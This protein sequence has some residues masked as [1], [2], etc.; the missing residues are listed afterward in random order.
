MVAA[1]AN[2]QRSSSTGSYHGTGSTVA[3]KTLRVLERSNGGA[4]AGADEPRSYE[5]PVFEIRQVINFT[6]FK[7]F[8]ATSFGSF[9]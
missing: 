7:T 6:C 1:A 8:S 9:P 2:H 5:F 4:T 3:L